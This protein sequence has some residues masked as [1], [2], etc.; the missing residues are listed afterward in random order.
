MTIIDHSFLGHMPGENTSNRN[1]LSSSNGTDRE[2]RTKMA[3]EEKTGHGLDGYHDP[4]NF[5]DLTEDSRDSSTPTERNSGKVL[6]PLPTFTVTG[7]DTSNAPPKHTRPPIHGASLSEKIQRP[8]DRDAASASNQPRAVSATGYPSTLRD[9][10]D[11]SRKRKRKSEPLVRKR[12]LIGPESNDL[13][14]AG[15]ISPLNEG[16]D[17]HRGSARHEQSDDSCSSTLNSVR[18][19]NPPFPN[20]TIKNASR[21]RSDVVDSI[22]KVMKKPACNSAKYPDDGW[23]Y[24]STSPKFPGHVKIGRTTNSIRNRLMQQE[25]KCKTYLLKIADQ[26]EC[27]NKTS[28]HKRLEELIHTDLSNERRYFTRTYKQTNPKHN[29]EENKKNNTEHGEWFEIDVAAAKYIVKKWKDWMRLNPYSWDGQ[30]TRYMQSNV[31]KWQR[32]TK[33]F[34]PLTANASE[35]PLLQDMS[36]WEHC[37]AWIMWELLEPRTENSRREPRSRKSNREQRSGKPSRW[38][39]IRENWKDCLILMI[40]YWGSFFVI[41]RIVVYWSWKASLILATASPLLWVFYAA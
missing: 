5:V 36:W 4:A 17:T 40:A 25:N 1:I 22:C 12:G 41:C 34:D 3:R 16:S 18:D 23:I 33:S 20:W 6:L 15:E 21:S 7:S 39:S 31:D 32:D 11:E 38:V 28:W 14:P 35:E 9:E 19:E 8:K 10:S 37:A 13:P 2:E 26:D 27:F 30:L 29:S 24:I